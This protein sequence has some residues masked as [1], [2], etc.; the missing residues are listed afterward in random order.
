L[1]LLTASISHDDGTL[2]TGDGDDIILGIHNL[3][4]DAISDRAFGSG[5]SI[6]EGSSINTGEGNNLITGISQ[7]NRGIETSNSDIDTGDGNDTITGIGTTEGIRFSDGFID[8][9]NG[10]DIITG[11]GSFGIYTDLA[12]ALYP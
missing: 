1:G 7:T 9:G 3:S 6:S 8:T 2:N 4:E 11:T 12:S 5:I 10:N